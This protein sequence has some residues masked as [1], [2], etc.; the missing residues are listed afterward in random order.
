[1]FVRWIVLRKKIES[2]RK[3]IEIGISSKWHIPVHRTS[4]FRVI[5]EFRT[6]HEDVEVRRNRPQKGD[7]HSGVC[8]NE[9]G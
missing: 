9:N 2:W 8:L 6:L 1:M 5:L 4:A 3:K 7:R